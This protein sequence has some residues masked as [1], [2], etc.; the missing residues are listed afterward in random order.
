MTRKTMLLTTLAL[1]LGLLAAVPAQAQRWGGGGYY[2]ECPGYS[3]QGQRN[4]SDEQRQ[5]AREIMD[6][7]QDRIFATRQELW[8]KRTQLDHLMASGQGDQA[9]VEQLTKDI[10]ELQTQ[11]R[12]QR[13]AMRDE[14]RN[15][16]GDAVYLEG[17]PG[18]NDGYGRGR[19]GPGMMRDGR[20]RHMGPGMMHDG[21]GRHMRP[22][23]MHDGY[24]G[25]RGMMYDEYNGYDSRGRQ[26][27]MNDY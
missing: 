5:Q 19:M 17:C 2:G 1:A 18:W 21:Q 10:V 9:K 24:N 20:G 13:R 6:K 7:H 14:L 11:L 27:R 25:R 15:A 23:M 12:Q 16:L 8:A 22:G 26:G 3:Y 4:L